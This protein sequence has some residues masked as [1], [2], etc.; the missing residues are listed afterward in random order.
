MN[1]PVLCLAV[2]ILLG[3]GM[4]VLAQAPPLASTWVFLGDWEHTGQMPSSLSPPLILQWRN[5]TQGL[6]YAISTPAVD[7]ARVYFVAPTVTTTGTPAVA[8]R[9]R[10]P[11]TTRPTPTPGTIR[12]PGT[13]TVGQ[14][15]TG[16]PSTVRAV[17]RLSGA[18]I[19]KYDVGSQVTSALTV[20]SGLVMFGAEDGKLWALD[21]AT[22][23]AKWSVPT[24]GQIRSAPMI[25]DGVLYFGSD[26]SRLYALHLDTKELLWQFQ[27]GGPIESTPAIWQNM[28]FVTAQDG[29][30][31]A[32][33]RDT[34]GMV[35]RQ[36]L[37][38]VL[39]YAS[40]VIVNNKVVVAAGEYVQALDAAYGG[41]RWVF[42][43]AA[44]VIGSPAVLGRTVFVAS[45]DG[46]LYAINDLTGQPMWRYPYTEGGPVIASAPIVCGE[47]VLVRRGGR[48]IIGL[49]ADDGT[50]R[51]EYLLPPSG[52]EPPPGM[53]GMAAYGA[54]GTSGGYGG[55][56]QSRS[57]RRGSTSYGGAP[58]PAAQPNMQGYGYADLV[59]SG[60]IASGNELY[61]VGD[62]G[63]LYGFSATGADGVKPDVGL[64]LLQVQEDQVQYAYQLGAFSAEAMVAPPTPTEVLQIPGVPPVYL[65]LAVYDA[66]S[67]LNPELLEL[68][69]D[70]SPV[71]EDQVI[72]QADQG[73]L[74]WLY[75]P[76]GIIA[77]NLANGMHQ[78]DVS[79][80]DWR[81]NKHVMRVYFYVDNSLPA[82]KLPG[83]DQL[84]P[85]GGFPGGGFPG[86]GFPGAPQAPVGPPPPP[87]G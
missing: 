18:E 80:T 2:A 14:S 61:M 13:P 27:S 65:Q 29:F 85:R 62:D 30:V 66:E 16:P 37:G 72:Y 64:A 15:Q 69:I 63:A 47:V 26:D 44:P 77:A 57:S 86:G 40:P 24:Q 39:T 1:K 3:S 81:G 28:L 51:W 46:V 71:P 38:S 53:E 68:Q 54:Y 23:G 8:G 74:W 7:E 56:P 34:G 83:E 32:L 11:V 36:P 87:P 82:P 55:F 35:W 59:R 31:Y 79:A 4:A 17:D 21:V 50:L 70:G 73:L 52:L 19:W 41:R 45:I 25:A 67:G 49:G 58:A 10:A 78:V 75:E 42:T 76:Q 22:G 84:Q 48:N 6:G 20:S 60:P 9:P 33:R 43:A 5:A 12:P